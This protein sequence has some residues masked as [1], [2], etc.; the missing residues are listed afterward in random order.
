MA[1]P[2]IYSL[3]FNSPANS[4]SRGQRATGGARLSQKI[5]MIKHFRSLS[6]TVNQA[7]LDHPGV[8][9]PDPFEI[10]AR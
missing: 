5:S 6:I 1:F 4:V 10:N 7:G 2:S 9:H 3:I 8:D